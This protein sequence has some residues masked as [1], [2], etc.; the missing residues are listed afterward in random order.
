MKTARHMKIFIIL[1]LI[2]V[3][4]VGTGRIF[5]ESKLSLRMKLQ[6]GQTYLLQSKNQTNISQTI[7]GSKINI[8]QNMTVA[9]KCQV[10]DVDSLSSATLKIT[11]SGIKFLQEG[12]AGKVEYDSDRPSPDSPAGANILSA[13]V[14][15]GFTMKV[16]PTGQILD[17]QGIDA[18]MESILQKIGA[19]NH[20]ENVRENLK[21]QYGD[22]AIKEMSQQFMLNFPKE[23]IG[24]GES[25]TAKTS[26]SKGIF[27]DLE[28][29]YTLRERRNGTA[30][31]DISSVIT[32][33]SAKE[34]MDFG[35]FKMRY[36]LSGKQEGTVQIEEA[37]GFSSSGQIKQHFTGEIE[38]SNSKTAE[39]QKWPIQLDSIVTYE[40]KR[41]Q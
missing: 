2:L 39:T 22:A 18:M 27:V 20:I 3:T 6:K 4:L 28:T 40:V 8:T 35:L 5:G 25:W 9:M 31:F 11:Y 29:T 30:L 26:I 24:V 7:N 17:I 32:P 1:M 14:D 15:A 12:T 16:S 13:L 33:N 41:Q 37:D 36:V 21:K 10:L 19:D 34:P 23:P 38:V